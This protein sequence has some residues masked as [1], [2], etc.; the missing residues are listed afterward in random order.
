[1]DNIDQARLAILQLEIDRIRVEYRAMQCEE[2]RIARQMETAPNTAFA[3]CV[4]CSE[5]FR[6]NTI[7]VAPHCGHVFCRFCFSRICSYGTETSPPACS[8]CRSKLLRP[9]SACVRYHF[10]F[11]TKGQVI[12]RWCSRLFTENTFIYGYR[13]GDVYCGECMVFQQQMVHLGCYGCGAAITDRN[14]PSRIHLS[15]E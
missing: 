13:C 5:R 11:N 2:N 9:D 4:I 8:L 7:T 15:F 10:H 1:M 12:C 6:H 14:R 3:H